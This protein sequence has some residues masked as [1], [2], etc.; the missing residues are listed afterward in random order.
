MTFIKLHEPG[1]HPRWMNMDRVNSFCT[2]A[3]AKA[4]GSEIFHRPLSMDDET[5]LS[6]DD[7]T[8]LI[9]TETPEQIEAL[10]GGKETPIEIDRLLQIEAAVR[11]FLEFASDGGI[12]TYGNDDELEKLRAALES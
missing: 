9:V 6:M 11:S 10:I 8:F 1:G 3:D 7:E 5:F 12:D 2:S 4:G